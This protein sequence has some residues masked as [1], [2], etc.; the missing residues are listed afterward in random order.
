MAATPAVREAQQALRELQAIVQ[1]VAPLVP[2]FSAYA[3]AL[4]V[5][6][7][8]MADAVGTMAPTPQAQIEAAEKLNPMGMG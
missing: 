8:L 1:A 4:E 3:L 5:A 2:Q 7:G 6:L